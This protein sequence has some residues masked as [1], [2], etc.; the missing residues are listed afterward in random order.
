MEGKAQTA[1]QSLLFFPHAKAEG[2]QSLHRFIVLLIQTMQQI[3]VEVPG[4][5]L[6]QLLAEDPFH[7]R[8]FLQKHGGQ[9]GGKQECFTGMPFNQRLLH[10]PFAFKIVVHVCSIEIGKAPFQEC[11]HHAAKL[12][13]VKALLI[14]LIQQRQPHASKS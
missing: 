11:V 5:R 13:H 6:F 12:G 7:I 2:I 3:V 4:S 14:I 8:Y 10:H 1:D 9:L